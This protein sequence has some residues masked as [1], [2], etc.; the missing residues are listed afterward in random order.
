MDGLSLLYEGS[1]DRIN[2][3]QLFLG[4]S[5]ALTAF[6]AYCFVFLLGKLGII[7]VT[8]QLTSVP[9]RTP[10]TNV[11]RLEDSRTMHFLKVRADLVTGFRTGTTVLAVFLNTGFTDILFMGAV[12]TMQAR[13]E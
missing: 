5:K 13:I 8:L 10:I 6:A 11:W 4:N 1:D 7:Q 9:L 12:L 2:T 3:L